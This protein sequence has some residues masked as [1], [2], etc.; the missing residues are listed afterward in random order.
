MLGSRFAVYSLLIATMSVR[1]A[2]AQSLATRPVAPAAHSLAQ[3]LAA[4]ATLRDVTFVDRQHGWAVGDRGVVLSTDDG[5]AHW[6][7]QRS[8]VDCP[9]LSVSFVDPQRGWIVGGRATP[10]AHRTEGVVLRTIDGGITWQPVDATTLPR[11]TKVEFFDA[12]HGVAA[13]YG[14]NFYPSGLF[15]TA[16]GGKSWQAVAPG[17]HY[18]WL[19]GDFVSPTSGVLAGG[20]GERFVLADRKLLP[21]PAAMAD[22]RPVAD[23]AMTDGSSGWMVGGD[24]MVLATRDGGTTWS[25]PQGSVLP[26]ADAQRR[27]WR[28]NTV[29]A[30]G[31]SVWVAGAPG[32]VIARSGDGGATWQ[33]AASGV[34]APIQQIHFVD[35]ARGW[36]V[37]AAGAVLS[38]T[39]GGR[40]WRTQRGGGRAAILAVAASPERVPIEIAT[41]YAAGEGYRTA[42]TTLLS[43]SADATSSPDAHRT[44][45]ALAALAVQSTGP[46]WWDDVPAAAHHA[47][48]ETL[49]AE[50]ERLT[51]GRARE[52]L[53]AQMVMTIRALR[54]EVLLVPHQR[55]SDGDGGASHAASSL[56]EQLSLEAMRVAANPAYAPELAALGL[57]P[58]EVKRAVGLLPTG[59]RGSIRLPTDEFVAALGG[60]PA[61]WSSAVRGLFYVRHTIAPPLDEL[62]LLWQL[63]GLPANNRDLMAGLQLP[64][65]SDARR[66]LVATNTADLDR[67][68]RLTQKR[69]QLVRLLDYAEG[70]PVW[71]AQVVNLTGGLDAEA[72]GEL[73]FQLAEGYRETGRQAMAA[74]TL[75][76]LVRRYPDHPLTEQALV[77]LVRYYASGE[78]A[79]VASRQLAQ[80]ART[81]PLASVDYR[82]GSEQVEQASAELPADSV[83]GS[84]ALTADKRLERA[85]LLGGYLEK[86]RPAVF[87][88][89][90]LRFPLVVASRKLGFA[91]TADR[92]FAVLSKS[93]ASA[94][95][96][97]AAQAEAWLASPEELPPDKPLAT[98]KVAKVPPHLDAVLDEP[99]WQ[100]AERLR[101]AGAAG[102]DDPSAAVVQLARD[103]DYLY[104][105]LDCPRL[106]DESYP[107]HEGPRPRD[108]DL[109]LSDRVTLRI[110][111]DRDYATS[112]EL[113][114]DCRGWTGDACWGDA[115]WNP[116]W[117]VA[118]RLDD[119]RW[120]AE[121]AVPWSELTEGGPAVLDTW[122]LSA[123]RQTSRGPA[124]SWTG[125]PGDT[126]AAYGLL[127]FR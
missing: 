116:R 24:G 60:S 107:E 125:T 77:W 18:T 113:S 7:P 87:A 81:T 103:A 85:G 53:L 79:H 100:S 13:G 86:A 51:D 45:Q 111:T 65:G 58:W 80:Q 37:G 40:T 118:H 55:E 74:D 44:Q 72:G 121:L 3:V 96:R 70:S 36:A 101:V 43:A 68:R 31:N 67:L 99:M 29:A 8:G 41:R 47:S 27:A 127:L 90:A 76:L 33:L 89:P 14:S 83:G 123:V 1:P 6:H 30:V 38:T 102:R 78:V 104:V 15:S 94:A 5:G 91:A 56:A 119:D 61:G 62:E 25:P 64:P 48:A 71:S 57:E 97:G 63:P 110:D 117:F 9:L 42:V 124:G 93:G 84:D 32:T 95:W 122:C 19:A 108:G 50:L 17:G 98:C 21:A 54:P 120:T 112:Y 26:V 34:R 82:T 16:D 12:A 49:L 39:D 35:S 126:P 11:L 46:L 52:Q 59:A 66:P 4:D 88:E 69:Q 115:A 28:W 23:M 22:G 105:A 92:Y 20:H 109:S 114:V 10:L 73:M 75:Y 106:R 2:A